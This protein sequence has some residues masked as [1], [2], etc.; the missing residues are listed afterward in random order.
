[1]VE[2]QDRLSREVHSLRL[3]LRNNSREFA[4]MQT[5]TALTNA[6]FLDLRKDLAKDLADHH[7]DVQAV[8]DTAHHE[9]RSLRAAFEENKP[10]WDRTAKHVSMVERVVLSSP[11]RLFG[12]AVAVGTAAGGSWEIVAH[13]LNGT[14]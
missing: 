11:R 6:A 3:D 2:G 1:M 5:Q 13:L 9:I 4:D 8:L 12:F 7:D 14:Q 10:T